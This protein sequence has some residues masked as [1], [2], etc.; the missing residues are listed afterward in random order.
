MQHPEWPPRPG[1]WLSGAP[2]FLSVPKYWQPGDGTNLGSW[3]V[4]DRSLDYDAFSQLSSASFSS[5]GAE[6][7]G[8]N[9]PTYGP[10]DLWLEITTVDTVNNL[11][12]LTLHGTTN[13]A[14]YE[15]F[16]TTNLNAPFRSWQP[17]QVIYGDASTNQ[18]L[19]QAQ[20]TAGNPAIFFRAEAGDTIVSIFATSNVIQTNPATGEPL[21]AGL[22]VF[23]LNTGPTPIPLA[24][25]Y[26]VSGTAS[27]GVDYT[28][29]NGSPLSGAITFA[30]GDSFTNLTILPISGRKYYD[31]LKL[32]LTL[33]PTNT[34]LIDFGNPSGTIT[35]TE[36]LLGP[37]AFLPGPVCLDYHAPSDSLI[38]SFNYD[39]GG[40][41][42]N[43]AQIYTDTTLSNG[44]LVTNVVVTNW[45]DIATISGEVELATAKQ[46][47]AGFTNG[48]M[49]FGNT[50]ADLMTH[51]GWVAPNGTNW[52]LNWTV[53]TNETF[54]L[55]GGLYIDRTGTFSNDLIAVSGAPG[56]IGGGNVWQISSN[57]QPRLLTSFTNGGI[58][59]VI[60]LTNDPAKWGPWAGKIITGDEVNGI[61]YTVDT[62]GAAYPYSLGIDQPED[63]EIIPAN[64][65]LYVCDES[66]QGGAIMKLPAAYFTNYV[67][68]LLITREGGSQA[69]PGK[70]FIVGWDS[71]ITN[72]VLTSITYIRPDGTGGLLEHAAFAPI[73]IPYIRQ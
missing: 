5:F 62:N 7:S 61:I 47:L 50:G 24:V 17:L 40:Y 16:G 45:T 15:L 22:F 41:P 54:P 59:G 51:V 68:Q 37:V 65:D 9:G 20:P 19:F 27:N 42:N 25:Y 21:Q 33:V 36:H 39:N 26:T 4:D 28:D 70:L 38:A 12:Y 14:P 64:Q 23:S 32:T 29:D 71:A 69:T 72:F 48:D 35:I 44:I 10:T 8:P 6:P 46:T 53:L 30:P 43:F 18:T 63:Y 73:D 34:Y 52:D 60:T 57:R 67:G 49:F 56:Q 55:Q 13:A 66:Y 31:Q 1:D 58:E 3:L 11:A 2:F